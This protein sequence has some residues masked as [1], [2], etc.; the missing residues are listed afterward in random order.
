MKYAVALI[1]FVFVASLNT[2]PVARSSKGKSFNILLEG[3]K[4]AFVNIQQKEIGGIYHFSLGNILPKNYA[5][6]K[7]LNFDLPAE[8]CLREGRKTQQ[9]FYCFSQQ[10]SPLGTQ[11]LR[12][13]QSIHLMSFS[14]APFRGKVFNPHLG[15]EETEVIYKTSLILKKGEE[16]T[17]FNFHSSPPS[18]EL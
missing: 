2:Q 8:S 15:K 16:L 5:K 10:E 7:E 17:T 18:E 3:K 11:T 13:G 12:N 1:L 4:Q 9:S 6:L 14:S